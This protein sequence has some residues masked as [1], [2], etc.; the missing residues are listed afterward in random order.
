MVMKLTRTGCLISASSEIKKELTVR[1]TVQG[2][3]GGRAPSFKVFKETPGGLCVPRFF[4][5]SRFGDPDADSRPEPARANINFVGKLR[6]ETRQIEAFDAMVKHGHLITAL[7]CGFGKTTIALAVAAHYKL[8]TMIVVHKEFLAQQWRERIEQ[9][10]PGSKI[11]LVQR[12]KIEVEGC[13]FVIAMLQSLSLKEYSFKEFE[14]IGVV[15]ADEAHHVCAR[16]FSQAFFKLCP[17]YAFA[18]SA[19]PDRKDGLTKVLHWFF[20]EETFVARRENQSQVTV[21]QVP[22][23]CPDFRGLPPTDRMGKIS[24]VSMITSLVENPARNEVIVKLLKKTLAKTPSR[25]ILVLSDRRE[26]CKWLQ[27]Q[28]EHTSGLYMGGMKQAKLEESAKK[29]IIFATFSQAHEGLDIPTLDTVILATPK[30]DI[31][32][33]IGRI[34]RET[35]GK[36]NPPLIFD[37]VDSWGFL[38][39]MFSKRKRVYR[40]GGFLIQGDSGGGPEE[41][42]DLNPLKGTFSF[43]LPGLA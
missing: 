43:R 26:H 41:T 28:F 24:L 8:R 9:F 39:A 3:Y 34:L 33:S 6:T 4:A 11:G 36:K 10:C 21:N 14:S 20:G 7:D 5:Q 1:P 12:D 18:L 42:E 2:D 16:V 35:T 23:D 19:T 17:R 40:E 30:S 37:I 13:D 15:F 38:W 25:Q 27:A 32:Q 22:F 29:T 31:K